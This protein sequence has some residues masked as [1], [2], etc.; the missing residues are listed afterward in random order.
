[1]PEPYPELK[2][3][4]SVVLT[5]PYIIFEMQNDQFVVSTEGNWISFFKR[6]LHKINKEDAKSAY[7]Y[8]MKFGINRHYWNEYVFEAYVSHRDDMI[9][10]AGFPDIASSRPHSDENSF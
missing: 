1:M 5:T 4:Y 3:G 7:E 2:F 8:L 9:L 10:L 6:T